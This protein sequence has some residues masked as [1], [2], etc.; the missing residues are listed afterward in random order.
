MICSKL[1]LRRKL[2]RPLKDIIEQLIALLISAGII[3]FIVLRYNYNYQNIKDALFGLTVISIIT[4]MN[5]VLNIWLNPLSQRISSLFEDK[6]YGQ[7]IGYMDEIRNDLKFLQNRLQKENKNSEHYSDFMIA[8]NADVLGSLLDG[9]DSSKMVS[10]EDIPEDR[11]LVLIDD[12]DR[13]EPNKAVEVLQ[14]VNLLFNFEELN[15]IV[16]LGIDARIATK[17]I[18]Q[19]YKNLLGKSGASGV[20]YLEKI[21]QIPFK[22]PEPND[23]DIKNFI[24]QQVKEINKHSKVRNLANGEEITSEQPDIVIPSEDHG[25]GIQNE[26]EPISVDEAETDDSEEITPVAFQESEIEAFCNFASFMRP[27]PRHVK[28]LMNIYQLIRILAKNKHETFILER[29][30]AMIRWLFNL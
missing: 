15:F 13:C 24:R 28:R 4:I 25:E 2:G 16:F 3:I 6:S 26:I 17:A 21:I 5:G 23:E 1:N 11:I 8:A 18:E 22:I 14:A 10:I 12:L 7:Q 9:Y 20:E 29:P 19:Y 27:N 30:T